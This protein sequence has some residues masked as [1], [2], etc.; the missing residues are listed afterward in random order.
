MEVDGDGALD[1]DKKS[2]S[3]GSN[4]EKNAMK[5]S[6]RA[7]GAEIASKGWYEVVTRD[8]S[9]GVLVQC[10]RGEWVKSSP[11]EKRKKVMNQILVI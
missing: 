8:A 11:E 4:G 2:N 10:N 3:A 5:V 1:G 7:V 6:V 9:V